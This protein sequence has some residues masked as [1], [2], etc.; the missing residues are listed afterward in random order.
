MSFN[1][2][3][4]KIEISFKGSFV[5]VVVLYNLNDS[6]DLLVSTHYTMYGTYALFIIVAAHILFC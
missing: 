6:W 5:Q 2:P 3:Q 4:V 1:N